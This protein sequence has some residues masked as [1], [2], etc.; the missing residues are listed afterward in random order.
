M[1]T[2]VSIYH[3]PLAFPTP[4][5]KYLD[6][7]GQYMLYV[8]IDLLLL[9]INYDVQLLYVL[10]WFFQLSNAVHEYFENEQYISSS[11]LLTL[12]VFK[13]SPIQ[14]S[15]NKQ[16]VGQERGLYYTF[17]KT[18][19]LV[20]STWPFLCDLSSELSAALRVGVCA[21]P[22]ARINSLV[23]IYT[24]QDTYPRSPVYPWEKGVRAR[25]RLCGHW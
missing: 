7:D 21:R 4:Y 23:D 17:P 1:K 11:L 22:K 6:P 24:V 19:S 12:Y 18:W 16:P 5:F 3:A 25:Q 15:F 2:L 14:S 13:H 9:F 8:P 10:I 20:E